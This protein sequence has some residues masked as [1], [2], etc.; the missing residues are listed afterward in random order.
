MRVMPGLLPDELAIV[1][2]LV[3]TRHGRRET[4]GWNRAPDGAHLNHNCIAGASAPTNA[5]A[6]PHTDSRALCRF[7][8]VLYLNPNV[9]DACGTHASSAS[10]C[11]A[12]NA[13][14]TS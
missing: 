1:E 14:G 6:R 3:R 8:A 10:A 9:P 12:G 13:A 11:P 2:A 7:A 4:A 5:N